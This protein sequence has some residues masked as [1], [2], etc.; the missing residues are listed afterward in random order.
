MSDNYLQATMTDRPAIVGRG[1]FEVFPDNPDDP[2]ADGVA[3]LGASLARV[4]QRRAADTMAVQHYDIRRP[5]EQGG[6]FEERHWSPVNTPVFD[7]AGEVRY[8][9]HEVA[10]VTQRLAVEKELASAL[11]TQELFADRERIARD[12]HDRVIQRLFADGMSL[13]SLLKLAPSSD[14]GDRLVKVMDDLD[15]TISEIRSTIFALNRGPKSPD[16]VRALL[17]DVVS[18]TAPALGF[19]PRVRFEGP[20]DATVTPQVA[21]HL[22]AVAREALSNA[23]RHAQASSVE[24]VVRA[25][26][27][28][29][30][31]VIDDERG[32]GKPGR[33]SGLSNMTERA[34]LLG[35]TF[36]TTHGDDLGTRIEWRVPGPSRPSGSATKAAAVGAPK[37]DGAQ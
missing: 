26:D 28:I 33:S 34:R 23:A 19:Q 5:E 27:D 30:L 24:V 2:D 36:S 14:F 7:A 10:D 15:D 11:S 6:G 17:L 22:L 21:E 12:L 16:G 20:V 8:I 13:A 31:E 32:I 35:G 1:L 3:N 37:C 29:V 18:E 4:L 25:G 9:I